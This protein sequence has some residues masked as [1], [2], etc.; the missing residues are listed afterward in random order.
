MKDINKMLVE[1]SLISLQA[2]LVI[3]V[4]QWSIF[5]SR[6]KRA[7]GRSSNLNRFYCAG[8]KHGAMKRSGITRKVPLFQ[9]K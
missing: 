5:H 7:Q 1:K 6:M 4:L 2:A 8:T 9:F 3:T